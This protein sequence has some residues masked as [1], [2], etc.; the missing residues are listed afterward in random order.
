MV[1][2]DVSLDAAAECPKGDF[3]TTVRVGSKTEHLQLRISDGDARFH[4]LST[5]LVDHLHNMKWCV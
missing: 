5:G 3:D 1:C 2:S 4:W